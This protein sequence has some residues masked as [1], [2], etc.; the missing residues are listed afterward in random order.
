MGI[1]RVRAQ[2][3]NLQDEERTLEVEMVVDTGATLPVIPRTVSEELGIEE[4]ERRTFTLAD[5]R[6]V[7]RSIGWAGIA[8]DGRRAPSLV[9]LGE[10][11]DVSLLGAV[12]LESLGLEAD[13]VNRTLRPAPQYL[14][15]LRGP[16]L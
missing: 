14:L 1:F 4:A 7:S 9:I 11:E 2:I 5:G 3:F 13:P 8:Y 6:E 10:E 16:P 12:A 15:F